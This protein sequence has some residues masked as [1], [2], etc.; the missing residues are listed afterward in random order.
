V[1]VCNK[2]ALKRIEFTRCIA[3]KASRPD[4]LLRDPRTAKHVQAPLVQVHEQ[5]GANSTDQNYE[6]PDHLF[7]LRY[8][9]A[10]Q[11]D[12]ICSLDGFAIAGA[13]F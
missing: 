2:A 11:P 9:R 12:R 7:L 10:K 13:D 8:L 1:L 3:S 4:L 5:R 6:K